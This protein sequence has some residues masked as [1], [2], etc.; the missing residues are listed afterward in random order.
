MALANNVLPESL[1][2]LLL[3]NGGIQPLLSLRIRRSGVVLQRPVTKFRAHDEKALHRSHHRIRDCLGPRFLSGAPDVSM[4]IQPRSGAFAGQNRQRSAQQFPPLAPVGQAFEAIALSLRPVPPQ[5]PA[6]ASLP[7]C[8]SRPAAGRNT[9]DTGLGDLDPIQI[10]TPRS[11]RPV[12]MHRLRHPTAPRLRLP[13]SPF[14]VPAHL[15][16]RLHQALD[17][18]RTPP[19]LRRPAQDR[20]RFFAARSSSD[21][22]SR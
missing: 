14:A 22:T 1:Q 6:A 9:P 21:L 18:P 19:A 11:P 2:N 10:E 7:A 8:A 15:P 3:Q 17:R 13:A 4:Q 12:R 16:H 20:G 5:S